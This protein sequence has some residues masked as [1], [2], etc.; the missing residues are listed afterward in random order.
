M[1]F[2]SFF[3]DT[4][5]WEC[6]F[7]TVSAEHE[8]HINRFFFFKLFLRMSIALYQTDGLLPGCS[9]RVWLFKPTAYSAGGATTQKARG[10]RM[11]GK[12]GKLRSK[13]YPGSHGFTRKAAD[14]H[15]FDSVQ[16]SFRNSL[17]FAFGTPLFFPIPV[18][19]VLG[20]RS[21]TQRHASTFRFLHHPLS[22]FR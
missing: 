3:S 16:A 1:Q 4:S 19:G 8:R 9:H 17:L 10:E 20:S 5:S 11:L 18:R 12:A 13:Y 15:T 21:K 7:G 2:E 14:F 22:L 6:Q